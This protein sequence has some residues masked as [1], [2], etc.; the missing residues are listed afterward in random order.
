MLVVKGTVGISGGR[1]VGDGYC[2]GVIKG[3]FYYCLKGLTGLE[4][5]LTRVK[6]IPGI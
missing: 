6:W 5:G 2:V 3:I 1:E 4:N